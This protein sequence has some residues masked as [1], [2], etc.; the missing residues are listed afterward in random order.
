MDRIPTSLLNIFEGTPP[1]DRKLPINFM[2]AG[3]NAT[4]KVDGPIKVEHNN[5]SA[6][7]DG[8]HYF[9]VWEPLDDQG[10]VMP[11]IS[12]RP[13][14]APTV[15]MP[16]PPNFSRTETFEPPFDNPDGW[17][18]RVNIPAQAPRNGAST[19]VYLN[20]REL[21]KPSRNR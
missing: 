17:R 16:M 3:N 10:N 2:D 19:G 20:I 15:E 8:I 21:A 11:Q 13:S 12:N 14:G 18:V 7:P 4:F 6:H 1:Q 5:T 9:L